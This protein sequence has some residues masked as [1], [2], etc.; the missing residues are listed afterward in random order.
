M[1]PRMTFYTKV[2]QF[3]YTLRP[4]PASFTNDRHRPAC[5][6][7]TPRRSPGGS[8]VYG[9]CSG[10]AERRRRRGTRSRA[11]PGAGAVL[12]LASAS[13]SVRAGMEA[14]RNAVA[15]NIH[16]RGL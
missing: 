8:S 2:I 12:G 14:Q 16:D 9:E 7:L 3:I 15:S 5:N 10:V 11:G 6:S 13:A 1:A 4:V